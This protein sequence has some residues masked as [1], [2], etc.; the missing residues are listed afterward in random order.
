MNIA[1]A[2]LRHTNKFVSLQTVAPGIPDVGL[3][4]PGGAGRAVKGQKGEPGERGPA[5][6]D[7]AKGEP[8]PPG[9]GFIGPPPITPP[10]PTY[11]DFKG[12]S[13]SRNSFNE[14]MYIL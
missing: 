10:P 5:G 8:G 6:K 14:N 12:T 13:N 1:S 2:Q 11:P 7:G 3:P 4:A 9:K